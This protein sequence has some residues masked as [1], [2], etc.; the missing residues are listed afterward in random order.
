MQTLHP[1][2]DLL[3]A[4]CQVNVFRLNTTVDVLFAL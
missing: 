3:T 4:M 2:L 1:D